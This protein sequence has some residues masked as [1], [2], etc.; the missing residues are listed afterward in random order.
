MRKIRHLLALSMCCF[1]ALIAFAQEQTITGTIRDAADNTPLPGVSVKVK[2][3]RTGTSTN[4]SG[5]FTIK[6][7]KGQVLIFS[8]LGY[9]T[10]EV[11]VGDNSTV[12]L[13]LT[14]TAEKQ[15]LSEVVVTAMDIKRN[16]RELS[17][18]TQGVTGK[19]VQETQRENFV[20]SLQ[21]RIAG[22]TVTPTNGIAGASSSIVI[23][24]FNSMAL[25]NEPLFVVDGVIMDNQTI[26]ESGGAGT[27]GLAVD[28]ANRDNDYTNRIADINPND[29]ESI[30][31]LKGPEATA[32]Y[33]SQASSGAI[34]ITTKKA[35]T[36]KKL[37]VTYD[38]SFRIS[39][40]TR[41]PSVT[42]NFHGGTGGVKQNS[43]TYFGPPNEN[44]N[45]KS[46]MK[47]IDDFFRTGFSQT[48][49][50]GLAFGRKNYS[51]RVSGSM[52]DIEGVVPYNS[53]R[54]YNARISNTTKI[55][56][57][58]DVTP[59]VSFARTEF[60]R[61]LRSANSYL[62][63]LLRW[64][65]ELDL[66]NI[67]DANGNKLLAYATD[68]LLEIDNPLWNAKYVNSQDITNRYTYTLGININPAKWVSLQG[69]FGYDMYNM[70]GSRLV[71]K[72][73][74]LTTAAQ[75][76][77]LDNFYRKYN[78]Y[79]HTLN[80]TFKKSLGKFNGRLMIGTMWQ[81]YKTEM[82]AVSGSRLESSTRRDSSNTDAA[83]RVRL[84]RNNQGLFNQYIVRQVAYFGE[85]AVNYKNMVFLNYTH[86]FE[87]SSTLPKDSRYYNYPGGGVSLIMTDILPFLKKGDVLSY[88]KLR[89][90]LALTARLNG[91]YSN[92]SVLQNVRSSGDGFAYGFTN[93]NPF[94]VPEK[95]KTYEIGT[96]FRLFKSRLNLDI[97]FYNTLNED[98][99]VENFRSSYGTGFVLN[100]LNVG[101]TRNKGI[102]IAANVS[103]V[104]TKNFRWNLG[105]NFNRMRNEVLSLPANVPEFYISDTWLYGNARGGLVKGGPTTSI[106]AYG[107]QRNN[108]GQILIN[109]ATGLPVTE[110][111]FK[112]RGDRNPDF[113]MGINNSFR[114]KNFSL[115]MLWDWRMG[116]DIFNGTNMFLTLQGRS[117]KTADRFTPRVIE[118]V[119]ND[120]LQNTATPT[121]NTIA[122][123]PYFSQSYFTAM[124]EEEFIEKN[125]NWLRLR[126]ITLSYNFSNLISKQKFIKTLSA[127]VTCNDLILI[128]NYSGADPSVN[129]NTAGT[130]GVGAMGFD[131]GN[132]AV[133]ISMNFGIRTSF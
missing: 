28:R 20:N 27:I 63:N 83:T 132:I 70:E 17:Y 59:S 37:D 9:K 50:L 45:R 43:F 34:I 7:N 98:Q 128:T 31:V 118:G 69:R 94:L 52:N 54:R 123:T 38:N 115:S 71:H 13:S 101:S 121:K 53:Y 104:Q 108:A 127:F 41:F 46:I 120:G 114:Y 49:N 14:E 86:R 99:I 15:Q 113:T 67:E 91:A 25:S 77:T 10:V 44:P 30:T 75:G 33:G 55:G 12:N 21:G 117:L 133:P 106:T 78:G 111:L 66:T 92:Q 125:I 102:E 109:P 24:G 81:D 97:T 18:S 4:S 85:A 65:L 119:L 23:R 3:G 16:P 74:F 90:S 87:A 48:H 126:D 89:S 39:E 95:Q 42:D 8:F 131:Y 107:Y 51:F 62:L 64:P 47:N 116:G 2:G 122:V 103:P 105:L 73:S 112:V 129:G 68:P 80:A 22:I 130:R 32:L 79:N 110:S 35:A 36:S 82:F 6:A 58:I 57:Y 88:W 5:T 1:F 56:K 72:Q 26:N 100:T 124:P 96:E 93:L 19:E 84:N 60:K 76:G 11:T 61:P 40:I 29:I